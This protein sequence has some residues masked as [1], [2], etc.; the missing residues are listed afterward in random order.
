LGK[1][2]TNRN[3]DGSK[4]D[5]ELKSSQKTELNQEKNRPND[6]KSDPHRLDLPFHRRFHDRSEELTSEA[7]MAG[8]R[9]RLLRLGQ[10]VTECKA[11]IYSMRSLSLKSWMESYKTIDELFPT[12]L[13]I[14]DDHHLREWA[15]VHW[16]Q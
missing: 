9:G 3:F 6:K 8:F 5:D 13:L 7:G 10:Q 14:F 16:F 2:T 11:L 15:I 1:W 4:P 12:K